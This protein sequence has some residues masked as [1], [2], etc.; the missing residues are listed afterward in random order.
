MTAGGAAVAEYIVYRQQGHDRRAVAR[1]DAASAEQAVRRAQDQVTMSPGQ[2]LTAELAST[3][4]A[5]EAERNRTSRD[6]AR[7]TRGGEGP[8]LER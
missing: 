5:Q 2:Q 4:D 3:A 7:D 8:I 6:L 1:I